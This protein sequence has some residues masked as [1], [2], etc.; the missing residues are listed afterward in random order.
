M[1][2]LLK[3]VTI[4]DPMSSFHKK[5]VDILIENGVITAIE[6]SIANTTKFATI[7]LENAHISQGWFDSSVCFGEPGYEERETIAHGLTVAEQSGFTSIAVNPNTFP[8]TDTSTAIGFINSKTLNSAVHVYPIGALTMGSQGIDLAELYDMK[9]QGAIAFGDYKTSITNPNL[10]KLA[11]QY[12]QSFNGLILS[13]PQDNAIAGKGQVNE[14]EQSTALG[15]RGIPALAE[16]LQTTRDLAILAYTGGKLHIPTIS[17]AAAV[18][19]IREAKQKGLAV[20]CS[21]TP[22]HLI[23]NDSVLSEFDTRYKVLPP[24]R[25]QKDIDALLL[26]IQDGTIDMVTSDHAPMNIELK[27]VEFD[28]ADYGT[29]GLESSF[30][31]LNS[32]LPLDRVIQVLTA[33]KSIFGIPK[34][35]IDVGNTVDATLFNP[36]GT[37]IYTKKDIKSTSKNSAFLKQNMKGKVYGIIANNMIS[38]PQ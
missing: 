26:G 5:T 35:S 10:L 19:L 18:N 29:I 14:N 11:L 33:G 16:E 37:S 9:Q 27:K 15:L 22:H 7:T 25:T 30:G 4:I 17:T 6:A 38:V 32:I 34:T 2:A 1:N 24:L 23:L 8:I 31:I 28:N 21:V 20:S 36:E 3:S 13:Y 12:V